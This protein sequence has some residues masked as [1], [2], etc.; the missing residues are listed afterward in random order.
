LETT[1][2]PPPTAATAQCHELLLGRYRLVSELA[3]GGMGIV[4]RAID[5][6]IDRPLAVKI[7]R[8]GGDEQLHRRFL[9]EARIAGQL[10]HPGVPPVHEVGQLPDGR[11]FFAMKLIEGRTLAAILSERAG[12]DADL[13]RMLKIFDQVVQTMAY[14]HASGVIHRDLKPLNV[15]VGSFG[16]VQLLDWGLAKKVECPVP[17]QQASAATDGSRAPCSEPV[18]GEGRRETVFDETP[19][20]LGSWEAQMTQLGQVLGTPAYMPPE[21]ARGQIDSLDKPSDVFGLGAMLCEILTGL[22]PYLGHDRNEVFRRAAEAD[23]ADANRRLEECGADEE[24]VALCRDCLAVEPAQ[25]PA[26]AGVVAG[27]LAAYLASVEQRLHRARIEEAAAQVRAREAQRRT[28]LAVALAV[29]AV[30][31]VVGASAAAIWYMNERAQKEAQL[32]ARRVYFERAINKSLDDAEAVHNELHQR[33][34]D[35]RQSAE[36]LSNL[37]LWRRLTEA[38]QEHWDRGEK[39]AADSRELLSADVMQRLKSVAQQ[40]RRDQQDRELAARLDRIRVEAVL[41]GDAG[42][43]GVPP[44]F[45]EVFREAGYPFGERPTDELVREIR[46]SPIRDALVAALDFWVAAGAGRP[47]VFR[48]VLDV[49]DDRWRTDTRR[50]YGHF[51]EKEK[52]ERLAGEVD[53]SSQPPSV[54]STLAFRI[55]RYGGDSQPLL[56]RAVVVYPRDFWLHYE[57][58]EAC[59]DPQQQ[60]ASFRAALALRPDSVYVLLRL[61]A[62]LERLGKVDEARQC[63]ARAG[64][65]SLPDQADYSTISLAIH[66]HGL[67]DQAVQFARKA[68]ELAPRSAAAH[69]SLGIALQADAQ[70]LEE[71]D[72]CF[73]KCIEL[74]PKMAMAY[75][76]LGLNLAT[77]G[78]LDEALQ[79]CRRA[80]ELAPDSPVAHEVLGS[81]LES[82]GD[83]PQAEAAY[84]A[85]LKLSPQSASARARL[86]WVL[87]RQGQAD[88]AIKEYRDALMHD[89]RLD[90]AHYNLGLALWEKRR[91]AEAAESIRKAAHRRPDS[92]QYHT[93]LGRVLNAAGKF[94]DAEAALRTAVNL[95]AASA[96]AHAALGVAL[97]GQSKLVDAIAVYRRAIELSPQSAV[98]YA[99]LAEALERQGEIDESAEAYRTACERSP[100][101]AQLRVQLGQ[102]EFRRGRFVQAESAYRH[103]IEQAPA[104]HLAHHRLGEALLAQRK[105]SEAIAA[106]T[107]ASQLDPN[108]GWSWHGMAGALMDEQRWNEAV[109]AARRAVELL[110][111]HPA[112]HMQLGKAL[113]GQRTF[114]AALAAL[115]QSLVLDPG[116][117]Q[118]HVLIGNA[119]WEQ[120]KVEQALQAFHAATEADPNSPH[121]WWR[122]GLAL[123]DRR[124]LREAV[125][126]LRQGYSMIHDGQSVWKKTA[127]ET[128]LR[129]EHS[130]GLEED[131]LAGRPPPSDPQLRLALA[132][133]CYTFRDDPL[134]A[135]EHF[136]FAFAAECK[137]L[138]AAELADD[139]FQ[140]ACAAVRASTIPSEQA[141]QLGGSE[142]TEMRKQALKWLRVD[143]QSMTHELAAH[144]DAAKRIHATLSQWLSDPALQFVRDA[145]TLERWAQGEAA[146][147]AFFWAQVTELQQRAASYSSPQ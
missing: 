17:L 45:A 34:S 108:D 69:F 5:T 121:G 52:L 29:S 53:V 92:V 124:Q 31:L 138:E 137:L 50:I 11:H 71:A 94:A 114:D 44:R 116:N 66:K 62:V 67:R 100:A 33:L 133:H 142:R 101:D 122:L 99:G 2:A 3:G 40:L 41:G 130:L 84:R 82:R 26:D 78:K 65:I 77:Q 83:F 87:N 146:D 12:V 76:Y 14:A 89:S 37:D 144:P 113:S 102:V 21:Q 88:E 128:L 141:P 61:G 36:L 132:R 118:A 51:F 28:R 107:K 96:D 90:W 98:A 97:R 104:M 46:Q 126:A 43:G 15:M 73:R 110:P 112:V 111:Q 57:L 86:A 129:V 56:T 6:Q 109:A 19:S 120:G 23:L 24:L 119:Y 39:L 4:Y 55:R 140:A 16:E 93:S 1:P 20:R 115:N 85:A 49:D 70:R 74:D 9:A 10:Q 58:A 131:L 79:N 106:F 103:A 60:A 18:Q 32:A 147:W 48:A 91:F 72:G 143:V 35:P 127:A 75:Y 135:Y 8:H 139:R 80:V 95:D 81:V 145:A 38:A 68:I 47:E 105:M 136:A 27:R 22:P 63:Y 134:A 117:A 64:Q 59:D 7:M 13:P 123:R 125:T 42:I 25:R 54:L 30:L